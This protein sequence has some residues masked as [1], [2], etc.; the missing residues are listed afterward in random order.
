MSL[1][2]DHMWE[3]FG[4]DLNIFEGNESLWERVCHCVISQNNTVSGRHF[5]F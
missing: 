4:E 3:V 1:S 5:K 2:L